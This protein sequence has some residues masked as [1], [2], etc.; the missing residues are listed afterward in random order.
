MIYMLIFLISGLMLTKAVGILTANYT[1]YVQGLYFIEEVVK[2]GNEYVTHFKLNQKGPTRFQKS[3]VTILLVYKEFSLAVNLLIFSI[4]GFS[5]YFKDKIKKPIDEL[6]DLEIILEED[7]FLESEDEIL[8][9]IHNY[10]HMID[11]VKIEKKKM[12]TEV[13]EMEQ[14]MSAFE[15][16]IRTPI[17]I[18]RGHNDMILKYYPEGKMNDKKLEKILLS[19]KVQISRLDEYIKRMSSLK[20]IKELELNIKSIASKILLNNMQNI[21]KALSEETQ[22][23]INKDLQSDYLYLDENIIVRSI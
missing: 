5:L 10:H 18:I 22:F 6:K 20:N 17:T 1:Q 11:K 21:G 15:H 3:S 2:E 16:D 7:C 8:V 9:A 14:M 19:T 23:K 4:S 13:E 12:W